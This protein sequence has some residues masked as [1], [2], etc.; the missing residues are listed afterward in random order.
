MKIVSFD[1]G[2]KN[3]AYC[4]LNK[5]SNDDFTI[6]NW[7]IINLDDDKKTCGFAMKNNK[8]CGKNAS[9][10]CTVNNVDTFYC[11]SHKKHYEVPQFSS[12]V[13]DTNNLQC[14]FVKNDVACTKKASESCNNNNYCKTHVKQIIKQLEKSVAPKKIAKH[15]ANRLGVQIL[16]TKLFTKLDNIQGILNVDEVLIENQPTLKN[17]TMKTISTFL[18]SYFCIRGI[19]D[20]KNNK[21][22][23]VI[24][25]FSPSNKLKVNKSKSSDIIKNCK[26]KKEEYAL[27]KELGIE[28]CKSIIQSDQKQ[29]LQK[30]SKQDD[31]CD[32]FLQAFFYL[33]CKDSVPEKFKKQLDD[34]ADI[35][36]KRREAKN[37]KND[38]T[39]D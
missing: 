38:I 16:A 6:E 20:N 25:F 18:Y 39:V 35:I 10:A 7:G 34:V 4:V 14:A 24:K 26:N 30:Y 17:P 12:C 2:I 23:Q 8:I 37:N 36:I 1:V 19:V 27:T 32:S 22:I 21:Q 29:F 15:N 31:L 28:Y 3:L 13:L 33:F 9:V 11:V 5:L